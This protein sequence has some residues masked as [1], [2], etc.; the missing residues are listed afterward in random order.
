MKDNLFNLHNV[1]YPKLWMTPPAAMETVMGVFN[2]DR[3]TH[4]NQAHVFEFIGS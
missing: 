4:P 1:E 3:M 2:E